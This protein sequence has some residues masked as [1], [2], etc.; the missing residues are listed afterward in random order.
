M[1]SRARSGTVSL[2]CS[3]CGKPLDDYLERQKLRW[4]WKDRWI[5]A[6]ALAI[7]I[8]GIGVIG[9]SDVLGG[10]ELMPEAPQAD[11]AERSDQ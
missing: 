3:N 7:G 6:L 5:A 2:L 4:S 1:L 8:G 11:Q 9:L 10:A